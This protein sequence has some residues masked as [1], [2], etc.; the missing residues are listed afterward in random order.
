MKT[1][2]W[3]H[4]AKAAVGPL[5]GLLT[6][7]LVVLSACTSAPPPHTAG[8]LRSPFTGEVVPSLNRVLA[9]KID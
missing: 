4:M 5:A 9:V 2:I 1:W 7:A 8:P 3:Q 6:G